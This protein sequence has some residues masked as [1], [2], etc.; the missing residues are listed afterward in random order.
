MPT[1]KRYIFGGRKEEKEGRRA[2]LILRAALILCGCALLAWLLKNTMVQIVPRQ[3]GAGQEK[4]SLQEAGNLAWLLLD[5]AQDP[6]AGQLLQELYAMDA[7]AD[8]Y[9]TRGQ[10]KRILEFFPDETSRELAGTLTGQETGTLEARIWYLWFDRLRP[11]YDPQ[12]AIQDAQITVYAGGSQVTDGNANPLQERQILTQEGVYWTNTDRLLTQE[13]R[14]QE[15]AV[16]ARDRELYAVRDIQEAR[17]FWKNVWVIEARDGQAECF[18]NGYCFLVP[19]SAQAEGL[20]CIEQVADL[21]LEGGSVTRLDLKQDRISGRLLRVLAEGAEVEGH[22][23]L[24]FSED[25]KIYRLYEGLDNLQKED[26]T[27]GEA[28]TDFVVKDGRIEAGLAVCRPDMETIRVLIRNS[29]YSGRFHQ[30]VELEPDCD[31][32][33]SALVDGEWQR[34][35]L[36]AGETLAVDV[37]SDLFGS[38]DRLYVS[39]DVL[40]GKICVRNLKR[41][42]GAPS[43]RG[44]I[45]LYRTKDGI[46]MVNELL[47]EEYLY[48]VIPSEMPASY[49]LEALKS[50]AVCARTY[51]Y[52]K[53]QHAG[54]PE[55][56]AHLD[57]SVS[58][59]VYNNIGEYAQCTQAARLTSGETLFYQDQ[60]AQAYYYSTSCGF[61][62]D[63]SVWQEDGA[64]ACPYLTSFKIGDQDGYFEQEEPWFRWR[65]EVDAFSA[66]RLEQ[67]LLSSFRANAACV[68]TQTA[69]GTL[70]SQTPPSLGRIR[71]LTILEQGPGGAVRTL[72]IAGEKA[73]VVVRTEYAVRSVLCDGTT[74]VQRQDGT[75]VEVGALLPSAFFTLETKKTDGF[76]TG[77]VLSGGGYG[78]GIGLSQ[79]GARQMALSGMTGEEIL[80]FFYPGCRIA[81]IYQ[82]RTGV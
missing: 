27:L 82:K 81:D 7:Q 1:G 24:P 70:L 3:E 10:A 22:G 37:D 69:E 33:V 79:N 61:G 53:M 4:I 64:D 47:L 57:D 45:E 49:P 20:S 21:T 67:A 76:V 60:V 38:D 6:G 56:G 17:L 14:F 34:R 72:Q 75:L 29:G 73:T 63:L 65:Y 11:D 30:R 55:L 58:D 9:L 13:A 50:Q 59:Q 5:T 77:Y 74:Q 80:S 16:V 15:I 78:H 52:G 2:G 8:G 42:Q 25:L 19:I 46:A 41:A 28:C 66:E 12:G 68:L 18:W 62:T 23:F 32:T 26:L 31:C 40:T 43:Y 48:A 39:P 54:I 35:R 71:D 44:K 51:A 36:N